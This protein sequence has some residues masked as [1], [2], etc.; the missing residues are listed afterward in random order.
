MRFQVCVVPKGP[1]KK[2]SHVITAMW[3]R[4]FWKVPEH[5]SSESFDLKGT[6][7]AP[8]VSNNQTKKKWINC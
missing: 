3:F 7:T 1:E 4:F 2:S 5:F 6:V 8:K